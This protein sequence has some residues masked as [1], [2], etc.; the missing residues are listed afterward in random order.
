[1]FG[2]ISTTPNTNPGTSAFGKGIHLHTSFVQLLAGGFSNNN[3][4]TGVFGAPK[5]AT[6]FGAFS[7]GSNAFTS[8]TQSAFGQPATTGTTSAFSQ[9][10]T[11]TSAFG[12]GSNLFGKSTF[13]STPLSGKL[14]PQSSMS[15]PLNDFQSGTGTAAPP[16]VTTGTANPTYAVTTE[17][18]GTTTLQ[19][20][21]ITCMPAYIGYSFEVGQE[22]KL[23]SI[24]YLKNRKGTSCAGLCAE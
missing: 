3:S 14:A 23:C 13:G 8:G 5:P 21:S 6:G 9:P 12:G 17:K 2:N 20:Q 15:Q 22:G 16:S 19:F 4:G 11:S 7:G 10:S 18:D 1:M 24:R